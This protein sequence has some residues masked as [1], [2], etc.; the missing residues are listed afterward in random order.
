[1]P[2]AVFAAAAAAGCADG[3]AV[4]AGPGCWR[5]S[6]A[7]DRIGQYCGLRRFAPAARAGGAPANQGWLKRCN[8]SDR[9]KRSCRQQPPKKT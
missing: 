2:A 4:F 8:K 9:E 7:V 5:R 3:Q 1:M 6:D